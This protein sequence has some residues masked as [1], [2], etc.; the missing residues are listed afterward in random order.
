MEY[1]GTCCR[2]V[3]LPVSPDEFME[4]H[5]DSW[6]LKNPVA[7][8]LPSMEIFSVG[9]LML[10]FANFMKSIPS[11]NLELKFLTMKTS[12]SIVL[13]FTV[14]GN[15]YNPVTSILLPFAAVIFMEICL[16]RFACFDWPLDMLNAF[17][18]MADI[19]AP[20]SNSP[21]WAL[22]VI[23]ISQKGLLF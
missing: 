14:T 10:M 2:L 4:W 7:I 13:S 17:S 8:S 9:T 1:A 6:S 12:S 22:P 19:A 20:V 21:K 11:M 15:W 16:R 5:L 23:L 3:Q 18:S